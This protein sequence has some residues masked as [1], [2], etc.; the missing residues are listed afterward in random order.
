[1]ERRREGTLTLSSDAG[2]GACFPVGGPSAT[3]RPRTPL[4]RKTE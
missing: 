3:F 4:R 2:Q 1:M